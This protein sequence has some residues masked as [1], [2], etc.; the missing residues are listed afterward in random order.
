MIITIFRKETILWEYFVI[1]YY[2]AVQE[3]PI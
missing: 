1:I 2:I 3:N